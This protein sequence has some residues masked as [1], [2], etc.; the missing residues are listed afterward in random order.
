LGS[1]VTLGN[2]FT[3][4]MMLTPALALGHWLGETLTL[5]RTAA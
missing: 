5:G 3:P 1:G 2:A 4:G